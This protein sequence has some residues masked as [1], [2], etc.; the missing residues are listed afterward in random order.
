MFVERD[1]NYN[2]RSNNFLNRR[3]VNSIRYG[4][5]SVSFLAPQIWDILLKEVLD[6]ETF[7]SFKPEIKKGF[8]GNAI[9]HLAKHTYHI[10]KYISLKK[11]ASISFSKFVKMPSWRLG[12][13]VNFILLALKNENKKIVYGFQLCSTWFRICICRYTNIYIATMEKWMY[14]SFVSN[15]AQGGYPVFPLLLG[16]G[17]DWNQQKHPPVFCKNKCSWKFRKFHKPA[18]LLKRGSNTD[19]F[20][21]ILQNF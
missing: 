4:T 17:F 7:K 3:R 16:C 19:V 21:W 5:E 13:N 15:F 12:W 14:A 18:A 20:L 2:L 6:F 11:S 9:L 1:C 8:H 10:K